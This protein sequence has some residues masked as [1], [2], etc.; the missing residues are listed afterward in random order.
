VGRPVR[1]AGAVRP[2]ALG[3]S[4][5]LQVRAADGSWRTAR[6]A[7]L[8]RGTADT[9]YATTWTPLRRGTYVWRATWRGGGGQHSTL[10]RTVVVR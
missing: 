5:A 2:R 3:S 9:T 8:Q 1:L 6:T 10:P 4:V 7:V